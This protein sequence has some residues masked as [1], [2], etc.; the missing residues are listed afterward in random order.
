MLMH[1]VCTMYVLCTHYAVF[2][3]QNH[4]NQNHPDQN[5]NIML[6]HANLHP[7]NQIRSSATPID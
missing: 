6:L 1:Y 5:H 2:V 7:S 4:G 3:D